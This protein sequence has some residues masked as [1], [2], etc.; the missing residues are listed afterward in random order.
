MRAP[1]RTRQSLVCLVGFR[2]ANVPSAWRYPSR[3]IVGLAVCPGAPFL[4]PG[5]SPA[6][7]AEQRALI[8]LIGDAVGRAISGAHR[9]VVVGGHREPPQVDLT[10]TAPAGPSPFERAGTT[11]GLPGTAWVARAVLDRSGHGS[12]PFRLCAGGSP[13]VDPDL[14]GAALTRGDQTI[15]VLALTEGA[16]AHGAHAPLQQDDRAADFDAGLVG[17]LRSAR[18]A[19]LRAWGTEQRELGEQL[20]SSAPLVLGAIAPHLPTELAEAQ[21]GDGGARY[22]VGYQVAS[23][24]WPGR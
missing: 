13:A 14:V 12:A 10:G 16:R 24:T 15:A 22:G 1:V 19:N 8:E 5:V 2:Q 9:I 3:V 17:A 6:L 23:W 11:A 7:A 20:G 18:A 21:V 4:V